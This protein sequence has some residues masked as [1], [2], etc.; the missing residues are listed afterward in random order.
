MNFFQAYFEY[1]GD[2]E[3]PAAFHRWSALSGVGALLGRNFELQHGH[4]SIHPNLYCMLIGNPGTRK[5]TAIKLLKQL[6]TH[7]G[8]TTIAADKTTK[9]KFLMD[10]SGDTG[11]ATD[12]PQDILDRNLWGD[13]NADV[14]TRPAAECYIMADEWNDFTSLG[15]IEFYSLL[16]TLWDYSGIYENRIKNGKSIAINNPTL[17]I[18]GG[19][20][21]TGFSLAFPSEILGQ[22][23]FSRMILVYGESTGKK[24]TFPK[25]PDV[26]LRAE[27]IQYMQQIRARCQGIVSLNPIAIKL[28]DKIYTT[29]PGFDDFRF[30]SYVNRRFT[31]LLKLCII[32]A[33]S[34]CDTVITEGDVLLANTVLTHTEHNMPKALGEFGKSR[35]SEVTN[36]VMEMLSAATAPV[37][38]NA[39]WKISVGDLEKRTQLSEIIANL[40]AAD[41]II[42][43]GRGFLAKKKPI[44]EVYTD[45]IDYSLLTEE[46]RGK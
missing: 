10:L 1:I 17:S 18:L 9:E 30:D 40:Q 37:D 43:V 36:K 26:K 5:S 2:S 15:N 23:F 6:I 13:N 4:F 27:L 44:P 7:A 16:G 46:E 35:N 45:L 8:Y 38:F 14:S 3:C 25:P 28:L 31:Q 24:I 19:N 32:G 34:R 22:G 11:D 12:T 21:P 41:K 39:I 42:S 29:Y 20:T 33:A